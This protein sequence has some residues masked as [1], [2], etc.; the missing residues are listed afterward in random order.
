LE[1]IYD[2]FF[3]T[4]PQG[5]GTGM[6]LSVVHGIVKSHQGAIEAASTPGQGTEFRVYFPRVEAG[7]VVSAPRAES[8]AGGSEHIL[9]V[10]DEDIL[11]EMSSHLLKRLGYDVTACTNSMDALARFQEAP[12]RFALVITDMTMPEMTG[13]ELAARMLALR[14]NLPVIMRTGFSEQI[15]EEKAKQM[16]IRAFIMKPIVV[17]HL[18]KT[19]RRVLDSHPP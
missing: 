16:G 10:D 12:E 14:P 1:R 7:E 8:I 3:T 9:F 11:V 19:I 18:A 5:V 2:P 17:N 4:K 15:S 13:K 6:G